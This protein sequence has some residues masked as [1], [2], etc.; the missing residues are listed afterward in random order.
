MLVVLGGYLILLGLTA[1]PSV[2]RW[3]AGFAADMLE[4]RIGTRVRVQRVRMGL[5]GRLIVDGLQVYDR[6]DSLML[7]V[8]R[9]AAKLDIAPLLEHRICIS[10]AQLFGA[11]A[12]LYHSV[13]DS[14][15]NWQFL[16]DAF[17]NPSDTT[18]SSI[19]L[20]IQS[21]LVRR[22]Q[23]RYDRLYKPHTAGRLDPNHLAVNDLSVTARL[24]CLTPDSLNLRMDK[25]AF[26]EQSGLELKKLQFHITANRD[27]MRLEGLDLQLPRTS[28]AIPLLTTAYPGLPAKGTSLQAWATLL[29][30]RTQVS[31]H[32]VPADLAPIIPSLKSLD[33]PLS[34]ST[35]AQLA[36]GGHLSLTNL[37]LSAP[38]G[39]LRLSADMQG[40]DLFHTPSCTAHIRDLSTTR[41]LWTRLPDYVPSLS[42]SLAERLQPLGSTHSSGQLYYS[43]RLI[44]AHLAI[45][46]EAGSV[47]VKGNLA[48]RNRFQAELTLADAR[49]DALLS[50][51]VQQSQPLNVSATATLHGVLHGMAGRPDMQASGHVQSLTFR[52][53]TYHDIPFRGS[54]AGHEYQLALQAHEEQG[55]LALDAQATLPPSGTKRITLSGTLQEFSPSALHLTRALPGESI[56]GQIQ[57]DIALPASGQPEGEVRLTGLALSSSERGRLDIGDVHLSCHTDSGFQRVSLLSDVA[58]LEASGMFRWKSI[59]QA[60]LLL[61]HRHLPSVISAPH[62]AGDA[63][64]VDINFDL[65]VRDTA[66]VARLTGT[67]LSIPEEATLHGYIHS[68]VNLMELDGQIPQLRIGNEQLLDG[69]LRLECTQRN[70]Q[71]SLRTRRMMKG[72]PVDID[73]AAYTENDRL[74]AQA[75]WDNLAQPA[76]R[77]ALSLATQFLKDPDGQT[78]V[79]ARLNP[80]DIVISDTVWHVHPGTIHWHHGMADISDVSLSNQDRYFALNGQVSA[81]EGDTLTVDVKDFDLSYLFNIINFHAVDFHGFATGRVYGRTLMSSPRAD[82]FLQVHDFTFNDAGMGEMDIHINWGDRPKTIQLDAYIQDPP[83]RQ[84]TTVRGSITLGH[85]PGTGLDLDIDTRR[86]DLHF[87]HRYASAIFS[88]MEG[89]ITGACHVFGPFKNINLEG[90]AVAEEASVRVTSLG[91]DYHLAGDSVILV[92][93]TIRF[94]GATIYDYLG[95]PGSTEHAAHLRGE[96]T[97]HHLSNMSY[98]I[99]VDADNI[100]GY[101]F[102]QMEDL[103][104]CGTVFATGTAHVYG[105]PGSVNIDVKGRPQS[106]TTLVYDA[107]SP[108]TVTDANFITYV[109][110]ADSVPDPQKPAVP[111]APA[112]S[113][114]MHLNFDLDVTPEA[115]MQVLMDAKSGDYINLYGNGRILANYY[116]KGKFQMYG[117]YRVDHGLYKLS[118]QDVIRK[119]FAFRPDGTITFGGDPGKAA[120]QLTAVYTVPNV[121]LDDLS[122]SS[123]GLS[124]TRVDCVMNIGG[125]AFAPTVSFDFD[126]PNANEDEKRMVRSMLSTDEER[127]M[128][129][130]YL[131][132]IG[133]FYN[134]NAQMQNAASQSGTA[135]NSLISSTLS[136]QF[137]QFLSNAMGSH[138]WSFG[139][140]LRT[141]ETGWDQLDIEGILSGRLLNNRLLI[142]GNFGYR[143]SYYSTNNFIGDFD[144]QY[145]LTPNGNLSLKAYNQTNDRYFIQSSLTTQGIGLQFKRDFNS[146]RHAFR[147]TRKAKGKATNKGMGKGT[148]AQPP[149]P[150]SPDGE[151]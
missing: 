62:L 130:I 88:R 135:M 53:H 33:K 136:S 144:V 87:L 96:L 42:T 91:V 94:P 3:L 6:R 66:V 1:I 41:E 60:V 137:N 10:N 146:W 151:K 128:Q 81:Q 68:G 31:L 150:A 26:R 65:R 104:F 55:H 84:Q 22:C 99:H 89:R 13:P 40:D 27:S 71:A 90:K 24:G 21:L 103:N 18:P 147:R 44:R 50:H 38:D 39:M 23:V 141:G 49:L 76:Q 52:Q 35:Q 46:T 7:H 133:R 134:Q 106:G 74:V 58:R 105:Q 132:G 86:M 79:M 122:S 4:E 98:D 54:V 16:V 2:Q 30:A 80:S 83:A 149:S 72:K 56:T 45:D 57:A 92:P 19:N 59:P 125:E 113:S 138:N 8:P 102:P 108:A 36:R 63:D 100:L 64:D 111:E 34:L 51:H 95:N 119:D 82:A 107:S 101:N 12:V 112:I 37:T 32:I 139:A 11:R 131:L 47:R 110:H 17:S 148:T 118:L 109:S 142:N 116:N 20:R 69:S 14:A 9:V 124:N 77:G 78:S 85:G 121:S 67:T 115:T 29:Q 117:T 97:H 129:V 61:T 114:D 5:P 126:L 143:E 15:G 25:L 140:N 127:N 48:D 73:M 120:L 75:A 145:L 28:L 123:L 70:V 93:D 43:K